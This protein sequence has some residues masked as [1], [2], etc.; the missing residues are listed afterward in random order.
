MLP[1][2][3]GVVGATA[4]VGAATA[5][6]RTSTEDDGAATSEVPDGYR[7]STSTS[8]EETDKETEPESTRSNRVTGRKAAGGGTVA[9]AGARI[10]RQLGID[11]H[12][13]SGLAEQLHAQEY[14]RQTGG[15]VVEHGS[16]VFA[17]DGGVDKVVLTEGGE[18]A[19]QSKHYKSEVGDY[20]LKKYEGDIDVITPTN[21]TKESATPSSYGM[22]EFTYD[23]WSWRAKA[24]LEW[25]RI[26]NGARSVLRGARSAASRAISGL[27]GITSWFLRLPLWKQLGIIAVVAGVGYLLWRWYNSEDQR[28]SSAE[29]E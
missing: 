5:V 13:E 28:G 15:T 23:D 29:P 8:Q 4:V 25:R 19:I 22:E 26:K 2:I 9:S 7:P 21:G 17:P 16:S 27:K 6:N 11:Y 10:L 14:A 1:I 18:K 3:A 24:K 12:A 20:T